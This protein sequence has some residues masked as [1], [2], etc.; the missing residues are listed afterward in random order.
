MIKIYVNSL[1][2]EIIQDDI[3]SQYRAIIADYFN[4]INAKI[5]GCETDLAKSEENAAEL[6]AQI[7][8]AYQKIT[9][10]T[11]LAGVSGAEEK[12]R[13]LLVRF[14][15]EVVGKILGSEKLVVNEDD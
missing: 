4:K 9:D 5:E 3:K 1:Y 10:E 11:E 6:N 2:A 13:G 14:F 12:A 15:S 8:A 7:N